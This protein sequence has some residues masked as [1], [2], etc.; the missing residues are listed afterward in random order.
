MLLTVFAVMGYT[1]LLT[2]ALMC[3]RAVRTDTARRNA[4]NDIPGSPRDD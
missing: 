2:A 4:Y 3:F 1:V